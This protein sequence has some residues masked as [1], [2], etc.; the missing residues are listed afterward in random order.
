MVDNLYI[1]SQYSVEAMASNLPCLRS[2][3]R[4]LNLDLL[5]ICADKEGC[6]ILQELE[7]FNC[8][9]TPLQV[10]LY[11]FSPN[12]VHLDRVNVIP[13]YESKPKKLF[14][15]CTLYH[16]LIRLHKCIELV[17]IH[18]QLF[19][20]AFPTIILDG[21][22]YNTSLKK[23][24]VDRFSNDL[25]FQVLRNNNKLEEIVFNNTIV[26]NQSEDAF[27]SFLD[28]NIELRVIDLKCIR[29]P[30]NL[31]NRVIRVLSEKRT[32]LTH[33][34]LCMRLTK[35]LELLFKEKCI[36]R[37]FKIRNYA[38][39]E[40]YFPSIKNAT[41]LKYLEIIK[42]RINSTFVLSLIEHASLEEL[43]IYK[44]EFNYD[45]ISDFAVVIQSNKVLRYLSFFDCSIP[46][47]AIVL[48]ANTICK[49]ES[50][51]KLKIKRC[52]LS[53]SSIVSLIDSLANN[54]TLQILNLGSIDWND[55]IH[56]SLERA[57]GYHRVRVVYDTRGLYGLANDIKRRGK[58]IVDLEIGC[59]KEVKND[60]KIFDE[61]FQSFS[62][63]TSLKCLKVK[64]KEQFDGDFLCKFLALTQTLKTLNICLHSSIN[65][66]LMSS[67]A[68]NSSINE[69]SVKYY[70][71]SVITPALFD[72]V[73]KNKTIT[74]FI[75]SD[76]VD[77]ELVHALKKNK[78]I[79]FFRSK[80]AVTNVIQ[81]ILRRNASFFCRAIEFAQEPKMDESLA[82]YFEIHSPSHYF[83]TILRELNPDADVIIKNARFFIQNNF[84][85][86]ANICD[87]L[88][89]MLNYD[90]WAEIF[91]YLRLIDIKDTPTPPP[92][93]ASCMTVPYLYGINYV[94]L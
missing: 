15:A 63:L 13:T 33:I 5:R 53:T 50:L 47:K 35:H 65:V 37:D 18:Q 79:I 59:T 32:R 40:S 46:Q 26:S 43:H 76:S 75:H 45:T 30:T 77:K 62:C 3:L 82:K 6:W 57:E 10:A 85:K 19:P 44:C 69:C 34:T 73:V 4:T 83:Q 54:T 92:P 72:M 89:A 23:I 52:N 60:G 84:F 41:H 64:V 49:N 9:L 86:I 68:K 36:L 25:L 55:E 67:L 61:L 2:Y 28:N 24:Y 74:K 81:Y 20:V 11:E 38:D 39:H 1:R 42:Y 22:E 90:C 51:I 94:N 29:M 80:Y 91:S 12:V 8:V 16:I 88:P 7:A 14:Y 56:A 87:E 27:I 58:S 93:Q 48:I 21:L 70:S 17:H 31:A 71:G 66:K 78:S